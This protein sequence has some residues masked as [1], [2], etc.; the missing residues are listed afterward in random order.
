LAAVAVLALSHYASQL[1][2]HN[3]PQQELQQAYATAAKTTTRNPLSAMQ[4][5]N[6]QVGMKQA[7]SSCEVL[8]VQQGKGNKLSPVFHTNAVFN[9]FAFCKKWVREIIGQNKYPNSLIFVEQHVTD[10]YG[11]S[12]GTPLIRQLVPTSPNTSLPPN[13]QWAME[14]LRRQVASDP[15]RIQPFERATPPVPHTPQKPSSITQ[16]VPKLGTLQQPLTPSTLQQQ[17]EK[18]TNTVAKGGN[19]TET[20]RFTPVKI[21][22]RTQGVINVMIPT[23]VLLSEGKASTEKLQGWANTLGLPAAS[24]VSVKRS[25]PVNLS[26]QAAATLTEQLKQ[27][28]IPL[29]ENHTISS[30][31]KLGDQYLNEGR[32]PLTVRVKLQAKVKGPL[33]APA[34]Q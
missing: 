26:P 5:A 6:Q 11:D 25:S 1:P 23:D 28:R 2:F 24:Q 19:S 18:N 34:V 10:G 33:N 22:T 4:V 20:V 29:L 17:L 12:I 27:G 3:I 31:W 30:Q 15:T 32:T 21:T 13:A 16:K 9:A 14:D 7:P 8:I